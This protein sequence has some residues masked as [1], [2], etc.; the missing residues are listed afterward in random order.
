MQTSKAVKETD[1]LKRKILR[2]DKDKFSNHD[3]RDLERGIINISKTVRL[4]VVKI[5]ELEKE[6]QTH[7]K[8][9]LKSKSSFKGRIK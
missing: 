2:L 8:Q 9:K 7:G 4:L 6:V 3:K 1:D 5:N